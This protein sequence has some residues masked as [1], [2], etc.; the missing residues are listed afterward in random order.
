MGDNL[1]PNGLSIAAPCR[2]Q[3]IAESPYALP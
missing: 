1:V 3:G 2:R